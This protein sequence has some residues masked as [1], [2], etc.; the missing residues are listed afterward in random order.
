M[1]AKVY[2]HKK[3]ICHVACQARAT[4]LYINPNEPF[5]YPFTVTLTIVVEVAI[6]V[7]IHINM[8]QKNQYNRI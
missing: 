6:I 8:K 3:R 5:Y 1:I 7:M 2:D 4:L